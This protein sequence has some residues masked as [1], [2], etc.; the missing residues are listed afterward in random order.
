MDRTRRDSF[1]RNDERDNS[2]GSKGTSGSCGNLLKK[3]NNYPSKKSQNSWGSPTNEVNNNETS[4]NKSDNI[5]TSKINVSVQRKNLDIL[6][7]TYDCYITSL[8][9]N[10]ENKLNELRR[11]NQEVRIYFHESYEIP[12]VPGKVIVFEGEDLD[13]KITAVEQYFNL[14]TKLEV[15][16]SYNNTISCLVFVP[17]GLVSMVIGTKGKQ[18][19]HLAQTTKTHIAVNQPVFKMCHRTI[20]INGYPKQISL[21][22]SKIQNIMEERYA[23]IPDCEKESMPMNLNEIKTTVS[24]NLI[25]LIYYLKNK[26]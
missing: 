10:D 9:A 5:Q 15:N 22:I 13:K 17:N 21:A 18:I 14:L 8:S 23:E 24:I 6:L 16:N 7:F 26:I 11:D 2:C 3:M 25:R 1:S 20:L 12:E 4:N 19:V